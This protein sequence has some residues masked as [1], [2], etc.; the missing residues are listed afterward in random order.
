LPH[1]V[2][3]NCYQDWTCMPLHVAFKLFK[4]IFCDTWLS[5]SAGM[6]SGIS[7]RRGINIYHLECRCCAGGSRRGQLPA[8]AGPRLPACLAGRQG[9][10][11]CPCCAGREISNHQY[12]VWLVFGG[13]GHG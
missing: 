2:R 12:V 8:P 5:K 1:K 7:R 4:R 11:R 9:T 3:L 10:L 6:L 13:M